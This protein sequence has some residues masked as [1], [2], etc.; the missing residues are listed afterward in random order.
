MTGFMLQQKAAERQQQF[1]LDRQDESAKNQT[2]L[3]MLQ[4]M[5]KGE[6]VDP[7][8]ISKFIGEDVSALAPNQERRALDVTKSIN[9]MGLT[10]MP[11]A[12][13]TVKRLMK[14]KRLPT[15][16]PVMAEQPENASV[17]R[18]WPLVG[19][20]EDS[21][22]MKQFRGE[23]AGRQAGLQSEVPY[24]EVGS[25]DERGQPT[26]EFVQNNR[27][28][29]TGVRRTTATPEQTSALTSSGLDADIKNNVGGKQGQ[30]DLSKMLASTF[31]PEAT[32]A[33]GKQESRVEEITRPGAVARLGQGAYTQR[34]NTL[35]A[36]NDPKAVAGSANRAGEI[37]KAEATAKF[38][39]GDV[40]EGQARAAGAL[41]QLTKAHDELT[42]LENAGGRYP[43][44][45]ESLRQLPMIGPNLGTM[46]ANKLE[47]AENKKLVQA[48]DNFVGLFGYVRSGV[49]VRPDERDTFLRNLVGT[50]NDP[51]EVVAQRQQSRA[52]FIAA[53]Q[54]Q[55]QRGALAAGVSLGQSILSGDISPQVVE[56]LQFT[57]GQYIAGF[58]KALGANVMLDPG[59]GTAQP[60][61]GNEGMRPDPSKP[62]FV[63]TKDG[64]ITVVLRE[65]A[66]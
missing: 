40:P 23:I 24:T 25:L 15:D 57:S 7:A 55:A 65:S 31:S 64:N 32:E 59:T 13:P 19:G 1:M 44:G 10:D 8:A 48:A 12:E 33:K 47:S 39:S 60:M 28:G 45:R 36:E 14:S 21:D 53:T 4:A 22:L 17:G 61:T 16:S 66:R 11:N 37:A 58:A 43:V 6:D 9:T 35:A 51:P 5:M 49:T 41:P 27:L 3:A 63:I 38:D 30:I 62:M 46:A 20:V 42:Q 34:S 52:A 2:A 56:T 18:Q 26:K 29:G 50:S 54:I